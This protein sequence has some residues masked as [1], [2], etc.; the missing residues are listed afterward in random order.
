MP[1]EENG[2]ALVPLFGET[3]EVSEWGS[4]AQQMDPE[5]YRN[6]GVS[7]SGSELEALGEIRGRKVLVLTAGTGEDVASLANL[8]ADV[9]V[10]DDEASLHA[11]RA[12]A[13]SAEVEVNFVVGD[14]RILSDSFRIGDYDVVYSGFGSID[15]V[16]DLT[17]WA[18]GIEAS[19]KQGGRLLV[20]DEHPF[21]H[22][23]DE[24]DGQLVPVNSY[25]GPDL[26]DM[27][28]DG[29]DDST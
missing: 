29:D 15:W 12:L 22:V 13:A 2:H 3:Q 28:D 14:S 18:A 26:E 9:T 25:F 8:G 21:S 20:Y 6:G 10:V 24:A 11:P 19:L 17:A 27:E 4:E 1:D 5:F 7:L 16:N 23:F